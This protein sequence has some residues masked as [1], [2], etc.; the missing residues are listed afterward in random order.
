MPTRRERSRLGRRIN[1]RR[2]E[3]RALKIR[4]RRERSNWI[5][6]KRVAKD[7][8]KK[9]KS[10]KDGR[11]SALQKMRISFKKVKNKPIK[12]IF[13]TKPIA[14]PDMMKMVW[15]YVKKKKLRKKPK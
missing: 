11:G 14:P 6:E 2:V 4:D 13:G 8:E 15:A 10:K 7:K 12:D 5:R 3:R 9:K 1:R